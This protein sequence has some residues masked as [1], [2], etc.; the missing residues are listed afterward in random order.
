MMDQSFNTSRIKHQ[1]IAKTQHPLLLTH[2]TQNPA[3]GK[4]VFTLRPVDGYG[5]WTGNE[6]EGLLFYL[7]GTVCFDQLNSM[8]AIAICRDLG[9]KD[10]SN[11]IGF[12]K[13]R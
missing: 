1:K 13:S 7:D 10:A 8:A 9:F 11:W 12:N 3:K 2:T 6:K 5:D 4:P